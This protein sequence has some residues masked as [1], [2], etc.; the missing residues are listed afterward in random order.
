MGEI[1]G[2]IQAETPVNRV[3]LQKKKTYRLTSL[4][5]VVVRLVSPNMFLSHLAKEVGFDSRRNCEGKFSAAL[6]DIACQSVV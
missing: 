6:L 1:S 2:E 4:G 3:N 5:F